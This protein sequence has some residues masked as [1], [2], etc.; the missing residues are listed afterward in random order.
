MSEE[1][2]IHSIELSLG[3]DLDFVL[4]GEYTNNPNYLLAI[5]YVSGEEAYCE[6]DPI[7]KAIITYEAIMD[8]EV[9]PT[10]L[11]DND[12]KIYEKFINRFA[13]IIMNKIAYNINRVKFILYRNGLL[14][15][16]WWGDIFTEDNTQTNHILFQ[17]VIHEKGI[18]IDEYEKVNKSN[19]VTTTDI[20]KLSV[21]YNK[22]IKKHESGELE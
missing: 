18:S 1:K 9:V 15:E 21:T 13:D 20:L 8:R 10:K 12:M 22:I 14:M 19:S 6:Y 4:R 17:R 11:S 5:N 16:T 7:N 3:A 2:L